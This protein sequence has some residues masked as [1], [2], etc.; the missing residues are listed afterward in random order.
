MQDANFG[1]AT[2]APDIPKTSTFFHLK[3]QYATVFFFQYF[4]L[5]KIRSTPYMFAIYQ[6]K[7]YRW[8]ERRP[9]PSLCFYSAAVLAFCSWMWF[10]KT[11]NSFTVLLVGIHNAIHNKTTR[12][13]I[14]D[15]WRFINL[16]KALCSSWLH[17]SFY[18]LLSLCSQC[19]TKVHKRG[20][21]T[22]RILCWMFISFQLY[23]T[24]WTQNGELISKTSFVII[25]CT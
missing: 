16:L 8:I 12:F 23:A 9:C 14:S 25:S 17:I 7:T 2:A 10:K 15:V 21:S 24:K 13:I 3:E 19:P 1:H 11:H 5:S 20:R 18:Y 6:A 22:V 4:S